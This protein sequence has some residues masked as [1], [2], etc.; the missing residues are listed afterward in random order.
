M[1]LGAAIGL[2][3]ASIIA[4]NGGSIPTIEAIIMNQVV[5]VFLLSVAIL[6]SMFSIMDTIQLGQQK[7]LGCFLSGLNR[8][9]FGALAL[10]GVSTSFIQRLVIFIVG[11]VVS[12][13]GDLP[14]LNSC[15]VYP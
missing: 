9:L 2:A 6:L 5:E 11:E 12:D 14:T 13:Y 10:S 15:G 4:T 8:G 7:T 1:A 3:I